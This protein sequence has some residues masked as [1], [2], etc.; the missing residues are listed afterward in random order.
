MS[1]V[2]D[3][4]MSLFEIN[5]ED[6]G[7]ANYYARFSS[8]EQHLQSYFLLLFPLLKC[9]SERLIWSCFYFFLALIRHEVHFDSRLSIQV[10]LP[11]MEDLL[12]LYLLWR[13]YILDLVASLHRLCPL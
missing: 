13:R 3:G 1:R 8:T 7:I 4:W 5:E 9:S 12:V 2:F 6:F 11:I 10:L